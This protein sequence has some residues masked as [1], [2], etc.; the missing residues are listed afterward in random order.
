MNYIRTLV[1][2]KKKRFVDRKFNLD[3][4]YITPRIIAMAFPGSGIETIY[5]NSIDHVAKFLNQ[6]HQ[7]NYIVFNLAGKKYDNV[8]FNNR[9]KEY[10]WVDHH[11]PPLDILFD[12]CDEIH[13][14]LLKNDD[15]V[16]VINCMAGKGRTGT[17]ICCYLLF[18]GRFDNAEEAFKYYS[19]KRFS[20][21]EGVTQPSQR[22][23]VM[24]FEKLLKEKYYFP[25]YRKIKGIYLNRLPIGYEKSLR[26]FYE[27]YLKNGEKV[28]VIK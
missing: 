2:G 14:F 7:K 11:A 25:L 15:N 20:K 17:I 16:I 1:S 8:K 13:N 5:R 4:S 24:Y 3:L 22:R 10:D 26:P 28:N 18:C 21:G 9:V 12:I 19:L 23:Y 6:R 27:L